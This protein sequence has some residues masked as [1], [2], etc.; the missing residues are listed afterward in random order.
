MTGLHTF[1]AL[2]DQ[3]LRIGNRADNATR[4]GGGLD[5]LAIWNEA[6]W[7]GDIQLLANGRSALQLPEPASF[8]LLAV[9]SAA[10]C[11]RRNVFGMQSFGL[12]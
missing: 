6:L 1:G 12:K 3:P 11:R 10:V 8:V 9:G 5:E 7:A 2:N 4:F